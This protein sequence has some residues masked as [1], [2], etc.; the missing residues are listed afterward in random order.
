VFSIALFHER[1]SRGKQKKE[2]IVFPSWSGAAMF[3]RP[4]ER[5]SPCDLRDHA[6]HARSVH[7]WISSSVYL[8]FPE[9]PASV[10]ESGGSLLQLQRV[11]L[12]T[13]LREMYR[14]ACVTRHPT[15][16]EA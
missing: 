1:D 11:T 10:A 3:C 2:L 12:R 16:K 7:P 13:T 4:S 5:P 6:E 14:L 15:S 8:D 9:F